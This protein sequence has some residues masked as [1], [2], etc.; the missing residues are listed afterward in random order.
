MVA[1]EGTSSETVTITT[2]AT[3]TLGTVGTNTTTGIGDITVNG[4][5]S[6]NNG[7]IVLTGDITPVCEWWK[8][9]GEQVQFSRSCRN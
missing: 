9:G 6:A 1:L 4:S 3:T 7:G 8:T 2:T 5:T